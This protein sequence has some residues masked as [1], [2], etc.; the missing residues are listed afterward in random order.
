MSQL[1]DG[2]NLCLCL[3]SCAGITCDILLQMFELVQY[4][5]NWQL[6]GPCPLNRFGTASN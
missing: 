1:V 6:G 4:R 2:A 3:A 5:N